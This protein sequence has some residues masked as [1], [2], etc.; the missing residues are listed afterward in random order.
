MS[1]EVEEFTLLFKSSREFFFAPLI[2]YGP[3][4]GWKQ[5]AGAGQQMQDI[6]WYIKEAI[7]VYFEGRAFQVTIRAACISGRKPNEGE[8]EPEPAIRVAPKLKT[9]ELAVDDLEELMTDPSLDML[10]TDANT[11]D[12]EPPE[13]IPTKDESPRSRGKLD[14]GVEHASEDLSAETYDPGDD[15]VTQAETGENEGS[16]Q[17]IDSEDLQTQPVDASELEE[18]DE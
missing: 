5:V 9:E 8:A 10:S 18:I 1:V 14:V 6:F 12:E 2:E 4:A 16:T 11:A 3:L 7:D 17:S 15:A 13:N